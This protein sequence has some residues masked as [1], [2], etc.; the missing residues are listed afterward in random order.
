[1]RDAIEGEARR[2]PDFLVVMAFIG[3]QA[4]ADQRSADRACGLCSIGAVA[5]PLLDALV[6]RQ[7]GRCA[8]VIAAGQTEQF[9]FFQV[10]EDFFLGARRQRPTL[11]KISCSSVF[12]TFF[13]DL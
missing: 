8:F 11:S 2:Q 5:F 6:S 13:I 4:F 12:P 9:A 1:M 7:E 10:V 3:L